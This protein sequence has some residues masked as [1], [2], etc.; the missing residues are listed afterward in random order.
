LRKKTYNT[1][2]W[3]K[4]RE[5]F[6]IGKSCEVCGEK[7]GLAIHHPQLPG[8]LTEKEYISFKGTIILCK[9]HHYI[10]HNGG[11]FKNGGIT[12]KAQ[13]AWESLGY[14]K[15]SGCFKPGGAKSRERVK[16][17]L[18]SWKAATCKGLIKVCEKCGIPYCEYHFRKH[19]TNRNRVTR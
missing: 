1:L 19:L 8:S 5:L 18:C 14:T 10:V 12:Y 11:V 6:I 4:K 3:R 16:Q 7:K 2:A 15:N 17:G 13:D 9:K